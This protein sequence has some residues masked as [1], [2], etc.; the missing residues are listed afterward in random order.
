MASKKTSARHVAAHIE[1]HKRRRAA[2]KSLKSSKA[3]DPK[4][5]AYFKAIAAD[6]AWSQ[7]LQRLFGKRAGDI[8]YTEK[9]R[10]TPGSK[11]RKL[12]NAKLAADKK[13]RGE[14]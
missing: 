3:I 5:R 12:H 6:D 14:A 2:K 4:H 10:G 8:R 1:T 7:E 13:L 9:G 11:L